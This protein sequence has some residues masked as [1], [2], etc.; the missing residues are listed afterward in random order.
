MHEV[1]ITGIAPLTAGEQSLLDMHSV[2]NVLNVLRCELSVLGLMV[3]EKEEL[4]SEG[5]AVCETLV[6]SL[7]DQETALQSARSIEAFEA[8]VLA[9]LASKVT[10]DRATGHEN[11]VRETLANL[12]SVFAILKVR[13]REILARAAEPEAWAE[14]E[15]ERIQ[16]DFRAVFAALE[17]NSKGRYRILFNAALQEPSD[18]Y[19]DLRIEANGTALRM[20]PV[21][22][23]VMR[24]LIANAR[25][26]TAP[27]G[28]ITA[29]FYEDHDAIRFM[30]EDTGRGIPEAEIPKVVEF[31]QRGSNVGNVRTMG[32]GFGLTKAYLVTKQ[33]GGRLW[34][35]SAVGTG[36]RIRIWI[37]RPGD[38]AIRGDEAV[39]VARR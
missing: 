12:E 6:A 17:K 8:A 39:A 35:A 25:K 7:H 23:D 37:P 34:I 29:A 14:F 30:V 27:G 21:F 32:G 38:I 20:P 1:E 2:L 26:Y 4:L 31:G 3:A 13:A 15:C 9:E 5:L 10:A 18:Y 19:V 22:K 28:R 16:A 11:D 33:F 24:D 36:T